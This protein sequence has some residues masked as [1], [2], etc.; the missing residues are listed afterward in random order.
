MKSLQKDGEFREENQDGEEESVIWKLI[1]IGIL[2]EIWK[3][4]RYNNP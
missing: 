3:K 1:D 2:L 4:I